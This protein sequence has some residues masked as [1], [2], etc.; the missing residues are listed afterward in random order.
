MT[1]APAPF[2]FKRDRPGPR[3]GRLAE[4]L[5]VDHAGEYGA[6]QIYKGQR[7]VFGAIP[8][9][10][11]TAALIE[12]MEAGEAHHLA[13]FDRLLAER[14][15]RPTLLAPIWNAAGFTLG[16]VTALMG[17]KAAMACTEA[18]EEV[19]E[20][21]YGDQAEELGE[22][23]PDLAAMVREFRDDEIGHKTTA[24]RHGA[25][26]AA[27]YPLLSAAIKAGCRLAIRLSEKI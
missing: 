19:I 14:H 27:G 15:V 23:E 3:T 6:V 16:A 20:S 1:A 13:T 24:E 2:D 21:H 9:R 4:M 11:E 5:R 25:R 26:E 17:E 12:E 22:T 18:V 10:R 8:E 7:A